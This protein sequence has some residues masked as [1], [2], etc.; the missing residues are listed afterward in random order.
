MLSSKLIILKNMKKI[1]NIDEMFINYI[2]F[3]DLK[4]YNKKIEYI[5]IE[6]EKNSLHKI[7]KQI[8]NESI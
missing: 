8:L 2:Y 1:N 5:L 3:F 7:L 4:T 6:L